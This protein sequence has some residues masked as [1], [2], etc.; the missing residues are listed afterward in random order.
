MTENYEPSLSRLRR[1]H[2]LM[3]AMLCVLPGAYFAAAYGSVRVAG[4]LMLVV[5]AGIVTVYAKIRAFPCPRCGKPFSQG[6][7]H[8]PKGP[9]KKCVHCELPLDP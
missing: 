5:L 9:K 6:E 3:T 1:L 2:Q 8:A 7:T 4:V